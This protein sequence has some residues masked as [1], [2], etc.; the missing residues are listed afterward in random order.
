MEDM[1][2]G[3]ASI[4]NTATTSSDELTE[5][6]VDTAHQTSIDDTS[7]EACK[8]SLT[9]NTNERVVLGEPKGQLSNV[10]NQIT[11]EQGTAIPV[12]I[13]LVSK[14]DHEW[15]LPLQDFLNPGRTYSAIKLPNDDTKE[16]GV[17]LEYL[18]MDVRKKISTF[19]QGPWERFKSYQLKCPHHGYSEPQLINTIYGGIN[20][21]YQITLD[22]SSEGSFSTRNPEEAKRLI[23]NVA[24]GRSY[25]MMDVE[26]GRRVDSIDGLPLAK[27]KESLD[28]FHSVL[29]GQNQFGIYQIDDDTLSEL[30]HQV[31]FVDNKTLKNKYPIPNPDSFTQSYDATVG[32]RQGRASFRLNQAFTGNRKLASDL[33]GKIDIMFSELMRKFVALSEHI[34]RLDGQKRKRPIPSTIE[35]NN[36]EKHAVVE[37]T[38]ENRSRPIILDS[39]NTDLETPREKELPNTEEAAIDLEEEEER[40]EDDVEIDRQERINVDRH[41]TVN[42]DRQSGPSSSQARSLRSDRAHTQLGRYVATKHIHGSVA[43]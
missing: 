16:S 8:F 3:R 41:T 11:S 4:D 5:K 43:T 12:Q 33:N 39:P 29:E 20:L 21:H 10:N 38:G 7:P 37:E 13:N 42:S 36:A 9:Y 27:I 15:K 17:S 6:S 32:S 19:R 14:K 30:E 25:E 1:D 35:I 34:K 26:R 18:F 2:F 40:L 22:T 31:D 24:M 28:S 23:K